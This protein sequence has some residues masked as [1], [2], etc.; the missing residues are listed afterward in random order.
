MKFVRHLLY[1]S[2]GNDISP[3]TVISSLIVTSVPCSGPSYGS[4]VLLRTIPLLNSIR[5][6]LLSLHTSTINISLREL[7]T[8]DPVPFN[9]AENS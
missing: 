4:T 1:L 2:L 8:V 9:P 5:P 6:C 7:A 3:I